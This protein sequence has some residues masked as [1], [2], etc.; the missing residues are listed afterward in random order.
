MNAIETVLESKFNPMS[1]LAKA[2][3]MPS[4]VNK[5]NA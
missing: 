5:F 1:L 2:K 3:I 4:G